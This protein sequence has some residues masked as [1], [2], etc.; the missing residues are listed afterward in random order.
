[1]DMFQQPNQRDNGPQTFSETTLARPWMR[2]I[3]VLIVVAA[4]VIAAVLVFRGASAFHRQIFPLVAASISAAIGL[5]IGIVGILSRITF[6]VDARQVTLGFWPLWRKKIP[7]DDIAQFTTA[8]LNPARF[9]GLG[10]RRAPDRTWGLL[11]TGGPG[12]SVSKKSD[13]S[14]F[15]IRTDR[16]EEAIAAFRGTN[17]A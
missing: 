10:L 16:A 8:D 13:G 11:F 6:D 12:L 7:H 3:G 5:V 2:A 4:L 14:T 15:Y 17:T 9:G 1:M